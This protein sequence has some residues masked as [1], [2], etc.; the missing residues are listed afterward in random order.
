LTNVGVRAA[1]KDRG[2]CLWEIA[3]V[4]GISEASITR[5]LRKE[6]SE[7]ERDKFLDIIDEIANEKAANE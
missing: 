5:K 2:V 4:L 7:S 6:L 1:A 3:D